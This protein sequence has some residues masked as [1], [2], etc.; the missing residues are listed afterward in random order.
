MNTKMYVGN[1]SFDVTESDLHEL[2]G[3]HGAVSEVSLVMDRETGRPR[4]FAFIT[5]ADKSG[6]D[7]AIRDLN[8]KPFQGRPLTV[9]EAR[10]REERPSFGGGGG[11]GGRRSGGG[12]GGYGG[13]GGGRG[14][15]GGGGG[16]RSERW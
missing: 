15:G 1:L 14:N 16:G 3:T 2:F 6:M 5:M 10:P 8:G 12:G 11:G 9:N 7:N 4:G 13:G